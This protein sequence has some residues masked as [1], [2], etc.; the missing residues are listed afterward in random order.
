[1]ELHPHSLR[2]EVRRASDRAGHLQRACMRLECLDAGAALVV[3]KVPSAHSSMPLK[4]G[5]GD[6]P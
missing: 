5:P 4:G 1:M 6:S 3:G 2:L